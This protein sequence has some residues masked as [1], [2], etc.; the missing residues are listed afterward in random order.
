[1]QYDFLNSKR[2]EQRK[3]KNDAGVAEKY[4]YFEITA[5]NYTV[6]E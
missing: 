1:M 5:F 2:L 6:R 3:Y 4:S